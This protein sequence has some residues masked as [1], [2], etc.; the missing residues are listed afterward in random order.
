MQHYSKFEGLIYLITVNCFGWFHITHRIH[1]WY[2]S[3]LICHTNQPTVG[4][5]TWPLNPGLLA[6]DFRPVATVTRICRSMFLS[7]L[8]PCDLDE[9]PWGMS[10]QCHRE[11]KTHF[12]R[13]WIWWFF[14]GNGSNLKHLWWTM[15]G[16]GQEI[17][18]CPKFSE[19]KLPR[20]FRPDSFKFQKPLTF[21]V[22]LWIENGHPW[23][24]SSF[25]W[26]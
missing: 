26:L 8:L 10:H 16:F 14:R 9:T 21:E 1:V 24:V 18:W 4:K 5:Y 17:L 6:S 20:K 23:H 7:E 25:S 12:S 2:I 3:L 22:V 13:G 11:G 19:N 15:I